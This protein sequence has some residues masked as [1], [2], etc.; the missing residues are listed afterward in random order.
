MLVVISVVFSSRIITDIF[1]SC[2]AY[3]HG[4]CHWVILFA[5]YKSLQL[6]FVSPVPSS[7]VNRCNSQI[8]K[9]LNSC[10]PKRKLP[11]ICTEN[12]RTNP[13]MT[14]LNQVSTSFC[15]MLPHS[16]SNL[17]LTMTFGFIP[18]FRLEAS[19]PRNGNRVRTPISVF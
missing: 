19:S 16:T 10:E 7:L 1:I 17:A 8:L 5:S 4:H 13:K 11:L 12:K 6:F 3:G 15:Q 14:I 18:W 9:C 2:L